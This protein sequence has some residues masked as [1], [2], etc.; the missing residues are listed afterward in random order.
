[1]SLPSNPAQALH[2]ILSRAHELGRVPKGKPQ[3]T[4]REVWMNAFDLDGETPN[5]SALLT[6]RLARLY[7]LPGKMRFRLSILNSYRPEYALKHLDRIEGMFLDSPLGGR[8]R[9]YNTAIDEASLVALDSASQAI[10]SE[11]ST[12]SGLEIRPT[13]DS[14]V[15]EVVRRESILLVDAIEES[16]L[17]NDLKHYMLDRLTELIDA[18]SVGDLG[19]LSLVRREASG[20]VGELSINANLRDRIEKQPIGRRFLAIIG[21]AALTVGLLNGVNDLDRKSFQ[22]LPWNELPAPAITDTVPPAPLKEIPATTEG[23]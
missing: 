13:V 12:N 7:S 21:G 1:M 2:D 14:D 18:A 8:W 17:D 19:G 20:V 23:G 22:A 10:S 15:L 3:P 16:E 4:A 9:E 5:V 11:D 6:S